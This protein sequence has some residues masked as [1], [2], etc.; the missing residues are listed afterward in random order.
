MKEV[1]FDKIFGHKMWK[2][3]TFS[4]VKVSV[5]VRVRLELRLAFQGAKMSTFD[6]PDD[7]QSWESDEKSVFEQGWGPQCVEKWPFFFQKLG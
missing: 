5:R 4:K 2:K 7:V 6:G 1:F 3:W